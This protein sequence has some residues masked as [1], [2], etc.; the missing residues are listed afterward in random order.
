[1]VLFVKQGAHAADLFG[2]KLFVGDKMGH[3]QLCGAVEKFGGEVAEGALLRR[4]LRD[5][6]EI[7]MGF[8]LLGA[9][10]IAFGFQ[11]A[12]DSQD[13]GVGK[14]VMQ[15]APDFGY[16]GRAALLEDLHDVRFAVGEDDIHSGFLLVI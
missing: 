7:T 4:L 12:Q 6:G 13:G 11:R 14:F 8:A 3:Q 1:M 5:G 16:N 2:A 15:A 10:C 9:L